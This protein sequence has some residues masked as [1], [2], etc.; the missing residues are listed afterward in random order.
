M[1]LLVR[2]FLAFSIPALLSTASS[3][4]PPP[5]KASRPKIGL[6][7]EGGGALGLAHVGVLKWFEQQ[8]I[9]VDYIAGTSM[10]GLIGG[11][12]AI[13]MGPEALRTMVSGLEWNE[14]LAGF[15]PYEDLSFR[16]KEDQRAYPN[17]LVLGLRKGLSLPGGLNSGH[18]FSLLIDRLTLPYYNIQSYDELPTPFRCVATELVSGTEKVFDSGPLGLALRATM[19]IPGAFTPVYDDNKVYVDGGL[20]NNLPSD[21]VRAMG[22]DIV[23]AVHLDIQPAGASDIKSIVNV[24]N[25][26]VRM[27]VAASE[28]RG[29][30]HS[31]VVI[32]IPLSEYGITD[33]R[34]GEAIIERGY[35]STKRKS[36]LLAPFSLSDSDWQAYQAARA[37]RT[38][39][40]APIPQFI[41]VRGTTSPE[42][43][44]DIENFLAP[45][46]GKPLDTDRLDRE[47]TQ[48]TGIGRYDTVGYRLEERDGKPGLL[49]LATEKSYAPP[50]I[51]PRVQVDGGQSENVNFTAA[52][53]LTFLDVA[54]FRSEWRTDFQFGATYGVASEL[55][56]PLTGTSK[57]FVAP[58]AQASD[59]AFRTYVRNDPVSEYRVDH[60][61]IGLD[62]GYGF[63]RFSELRV[64][65]EIGYLDT[66]L[67]LGTPQFASVSGRTGAALLRY[68]MDRTDDPVVPRKGFRTET[69]FRWYDTSPGASGGFPVLSTSLGYFQPVSNTASV[70][71]TGNGGTT[72]SFRETGIPQFFLGGPANLSAYGLNE[73]A[74]N[75]FYYFRAGYLHEIWTMPPL[76]GKKVYAVGSY[77]FGKMYG[78]VNQSRFPNDVAVGV[79]AETAIGP[80]FIGG[81]VGDTGHRKWF[82]QLGRVF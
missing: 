6:A 62:L 80:M 51:Q 79:L 37:Q 61:S 46:E 70:F 32:S 28:M 17:A 1:R 16:R 2:L 35:E 4:Q 47:L 72:F 36:I 13:G 74:G 19:A 76:I 55:Y 31:D 9:P 41:D 52:S 82:F 7:L 66:Q 48:L 71:L 18:Q 53:R 50:T 56:R 25:Q 15:T 14:I 30:A 8:H 33:Y 64:G 34:K 3:A 24:L 11:F 54:G 10:G 59:R 73:L 45:L 26:S 21:V 42:R 68:L 5:R 43:A 81:S 44:L 23:I 60:A 57:W 69:D 29:I 77:E 20:V 40:I 49:I 78:A 12:Y 58:H 67:R 38:R 75:Q 27:I 63:G 65:Y 22:A 39:K